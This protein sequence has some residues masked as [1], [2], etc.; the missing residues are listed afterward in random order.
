MYYAA[1]PHELNYL[2]QMKKE[3]KQFR[4]ADKRL[5]E[6]SEDVTDQEFCYEALKKVSRSFAVVIQQ[7]PKELQDPVCLFYLILR[8]LDT[9]EDDMSLDQ[10]KKEELLISFADRINEAPFTLKGV[11]DTQDYQDL[12]ENFDRVLRVYQSLGEGYRKVITEITREMAS[13]MN[14]YAQKEVLSYSDWDDY[15]YYVAGLVGIGLSELFL[16]SE[17][18]SNPLLEEKN[19][20]NEMGLF[21]Q[22]TNI[23][24][25]FAEDLEQGRVFWPKAAWE[26]RVNEIKE[27]AVNNKVGVEALNE[28]VINALR[29]APTCLKYLRSLQNDKIYRFCAIP[30][31]MAIATLE[32]LYGNEKVMHENVK[33]RRGKTARYFMAIEG[34]DATKKEFLK[35]LTH[36]ASKDKTG[37]VK[38]IIQSIDE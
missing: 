8:G 12:M 11:G 24:R 34:Y 25:D 19:F 28:V 2:L 14:K 9:V 5:T 30:Q 33:I 35:I 3:F 1:R 27:L 38:E 23:V 37:K 7:L 18:E 13:G 31:L 16:A 17:L 21:L 22:K 20:S 29:H 36:I 10:G 15:C 6:L 26:N 4:P 32:E